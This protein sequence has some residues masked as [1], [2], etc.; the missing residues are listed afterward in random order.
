MKLETTMP[1]LVC[2]HDI[3]DSAFVQE[4]VAVVQQQGV[5]EGVVIGADGDIPEN[6]VSYV[7]DYVLFGCRKIN[8]VHKA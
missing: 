5:V 8:C 4:A 1:D 3:H 2:V 6:R 7:L